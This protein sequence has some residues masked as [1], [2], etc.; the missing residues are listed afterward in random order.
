MS[1]VQNPKFYHLL[2][3]FQQ[4]TG[5]GMLINTSFNV[6][7]EPIVDSPEQAING[8]LSTQMDYLVLDSF[9]VSKK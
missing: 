5:V 1:K 4:R 9:L 6:R 2:K 8:F 7:D 3:S